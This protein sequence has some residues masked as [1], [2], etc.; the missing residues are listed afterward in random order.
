MNPDGGDKKKAEKAKRIQDAKKARDV[1]A[2]KKVRVRNMRKK[3]QK[4]NKSSMHTYIY[5][6][7]K[8]N[9]KKTIP[10]SIF[11]ENRFFLIQILGGSLFRG[12]A[13]KCSR[14]S[15]IEISKCEAS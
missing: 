9:S 1:A 8:K 4:V 5:M 11:R 15:A 12:Y 13:G 7:S 6:V 2:E 10:P 3:T 14:S